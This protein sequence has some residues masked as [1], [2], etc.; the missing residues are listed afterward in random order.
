MNDHV[1]PAVHLVPQGAGNVLPGIDPGSTDGVSQKRAR[2]ELP[3][4]VQELGGLQERLWAEQARS[5]LVVLQGMDT[6]G[7][8]GTVKHVLGAM[9]PGGTRVVNFKKPSPEELAHDFLWRILPR[10]PRPGEV[11]VFNRSHYEDVVAV[12]AWALAPESVWR[13]RFE[14]INT[15]ERELAQA[16]IH[17][18]KLFL[19]ISYD[20][21]RRR[22]LARLD[23]PDKRWKFDLADLD[24]RQ[25]WTAFQ[26][27]YEEALSR[28]STDDAPWYVIPADHKWYRNWVVARL[29]EEV[30]SEMDPHYPQ[31]DLDIEDL[32][33]RLAPPN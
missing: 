12:R 9:N 29:L 27:A 14:Q 4:A 2:A 3:E 20:E 32:Q 6:S 33:R 24:A 16:G 26:N 30:L 31:P 10:V 25:R 19:H 15:F 13:P 11:T 22:L 5:V 23:H 17:I 7:K 28:C 18:I 8:D 1:A 21:Q